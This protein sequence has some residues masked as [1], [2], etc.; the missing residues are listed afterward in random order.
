MDSD[1][2]L[3]MA[4]KYYKKIE[5]QI[6]KFENL[7]Q[8]ED[9][10]TE[11]G[12]KKNKYKIQFPFKR[13]NIRETGASL[14]IIKKRFENLKNRKGNN[15]DLIIK[16]PTLRPELNLTKKDIGYEPLKWVDSEFKQIKIGKMY[17]DNEPIDEPILESE[18]YELNLITDY[19][20]ELQRLKCN[21]NGYISSVGLF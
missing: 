16:S 9:L 6:I 4:Q 8:N 20:H 19:F 7:P 5:E 10:F 2:N 14:K 1:K 17:S 3:I 11:K 15:I 18:Y 21:R 12:I 13:F